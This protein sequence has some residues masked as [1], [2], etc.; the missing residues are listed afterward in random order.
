MGDIVVTL[1]NEMTSNLST[2]ERGERKHTVAVLLKEYSSLLVTSRDTNNYLTKKVKK[3]NLY[4]GI[5]RNC[6]GNSNKEE[7]PPFYTECLVQ[8]L[9]TFLI[10]RRRARARN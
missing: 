3:H 10:S 5:N 2:A 8:F 7:T 9:G 1:A 4:S 6:L